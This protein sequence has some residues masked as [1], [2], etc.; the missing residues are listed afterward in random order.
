[1]SGFSPSKTM[2]QFDKKILIFSS[3]EL[4]MFLTF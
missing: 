4:E 2:I 3:C 1:M